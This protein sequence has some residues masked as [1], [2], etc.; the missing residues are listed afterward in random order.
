M[1]VAIIGGGFLGGALA[2]A[3]APEPIVVTRSGADGTTALDITR[4]SADAMTHALRECTK[5]IIAV[6][7]GRTQDRRALYVE[8]TRRVIATSTTWTRIVYIGSTSALPDVDGWVDESTTTPPTTERGLVQREAE[9]VVRVHAE[10]HDIPWLVLRLGGL[11]G[12]GR[13]IGQIYRRRA[14][15]PLPGDGNTPTN[16]IHRDDAV[17]AAVAALDAPASLRGIVHVCDDDHATRKAMYGPA[18]AWQADADPSAPP[19]GKR[20]SNLMLKT[21]LGVRLRHPMHL[22]LAKE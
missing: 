16:L 14:D 10:V 9:A 17:A 13:P 8:G 6:A 7:P 21:A 2:R 5:V 20:I 15:A 11:Y 18:V 3:L 12:P 22:P 19:R 1:T 4:A